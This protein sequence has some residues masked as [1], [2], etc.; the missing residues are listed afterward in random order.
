MANN[1][2]VQ[3][4]QSQNATMKNKQDDPYQKLSIA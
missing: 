1:S 4:Y 3:P 2:E